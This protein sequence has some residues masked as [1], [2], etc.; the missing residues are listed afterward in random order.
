MMP[1][2]SR[3]A[4]GG[5]LLIAAALTVTCGTFVSAQR[6]APKGDQ[7]PD[8]AAAAQQQAQDQDIQAVYHMAD[9]AMAG[10][11]PAD[12]PIQLQTDFLKA[13]AGR[14]WVPLTMTLDPAKSTVGPLTLYLR[15]TPRGMSAPA[16]APAPAAAPAEP[17]KDGKDKDKKKKDDKDK[18]GAAPPAPPAASYPY[19]DVALLDLKAPA[20]GQPLRIQRGIGVPPGSYD[21]YI[22]MHERG[23]TGKSSVL[24]QPLDVPNYASGELMTSTIILAERVDQLAAPVAT[25]QQ[26]EH[27]YAFGQTEI[28]ISP[29]RRFKKSQELIVLF[30]IYNPNLTPDKKFYLEATYTFYRQEAGAEK[31]FNSTEPQKF[32]NES[33]GPNFDPTGATSSIQAGQGIPLQS[34]PDGPYRLEV[35]IT[36]KQ[37][38]KVLTQSINFTV[39]P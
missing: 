8:A 18:K 3:G 11:A 7:K 16:P 28:V 13:Q 4:W 21:L 26:S 23:A 37:S 32:D 2:S 22:V 5:R 34:F 33:M 39:T 17:A 27:P 35:K 6:P 29:E 38:T 1:V 14:V 9:A 30:Q 19:Q 12:F 36:D 10:Q 20:P 15:V 24:K 31:R 25:D